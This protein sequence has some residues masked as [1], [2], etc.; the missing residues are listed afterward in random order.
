MRRHVSAACLLLAWLF[1]NGAV[2]NVVQVVGWARML[3]DYSQVM[4]VAQA[5]QITFDGSAPCELCRI[6]QQA[7]DADRDQLPR[8]A[9]LGGGMEKLLLLSESVP[10]IVVTAPELAWPGATNDAGLTRTKAVP[11][12][13]PRV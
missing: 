6:S 2:W 8:D 4:P 11:V 12:R 7:Q 1:T 9:A 13:P 10:A 5:L 3:H